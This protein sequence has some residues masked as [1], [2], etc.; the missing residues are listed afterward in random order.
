MQVE[1]TTQKIIGEL[2]KSEISTDMKSLEASEWIV[3]E[4]DH[5]EIIGAA[6]I[7]GLFNTSSININKKF[8][9]KGYGKKIQERL[10]REARE[11]NYSFI[12]VFVDPRNESSVKMHDGIGYKT[13]F[14]IHYSKKIIQDI[15]III[16]DDKGKM[17][18]NI[19]SIFNTKF[20]IFFLACFLKL[21]RKLFKKIFAYDEN[22]VPSPN[23]KYILTKFEKI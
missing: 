21:S 8:R 12:T 1:K 9:G 6:G 11:R 17:I 23:I 2:R 7:G 4:K 5:N 3:F 18:E 16:F 10:V 19:L 14:R 13:I 22:E 15:K 20:G